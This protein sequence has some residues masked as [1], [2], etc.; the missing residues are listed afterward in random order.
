[1]KEL[2]IERARCNF[3]R[4]VSLILLFTFT[5]RQ[6]AFAYSI[7]AAYWTIPHRQDANLLISSKSLLQREGVSFIKD[8]L[9]QGILN[10][11]NP[12]TGYQNILKSVTQGASKS[13][14]GFF[15]FTSNVP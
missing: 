6:L 11:I 8:F 10:Q 15:R 1:M 9:K 7:Q 13:I 14:N 2:M 5:S 3:V 12:I 4:L